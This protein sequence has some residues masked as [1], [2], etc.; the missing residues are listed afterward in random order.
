VAVVVTIAVSAE[1]SDAAAGVLHRFEA[2]G[3]EIRGEDALP[4]P[5]MAAL[6]PG[7][8]EVRGFFEGRPP[9]E[10]AA[11]ALR[12]L[13]GVD[14]WVE[15]LPLEDWTASWRQHFRPVHRGRVLVVAPWMNEPAPHGAVRVVVEP[16]MAFGT[17][18]HPTTGLCLE[19]LDLFLQR[20]PGASVL[21]VGTGSGILAIAAHQLGAGLTVATD[22]DPIA[23]RT[24][25]ENAIA[26]Q[27]VIDVRPEIP[28]E[29]KFDLVLA[30]ILSN[31]LIEL[32]P[33]LARAVAPGGRLVLSGI[34]TGQVEEVTRVYRRLLH[35]GSVAFEG[36]WACIT[37]E[38]SRD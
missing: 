26:N 16:A 4:P 19:A 5:G 22:N 15:D 32:A 24:A 8:A 37:F 30:N 27:V 1:L 3:V 21:D 35:F 13:M 23:L 18:D 36:D 25:R 17:G 28:G 34:L 7:R 38:A 20:L 10:E 14:P 9:A 11:D 2:S 33:E 6:D 29:V 31:T 12:A